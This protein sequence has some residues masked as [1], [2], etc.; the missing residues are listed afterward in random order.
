M[1]KRGDNG[2][3]GDAYTSIYLVLYLMEEPRCKWGSV[4]VFLGSGGKIGNEVL[5]R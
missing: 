2:T 4:Y 3:K 1:L 5:L